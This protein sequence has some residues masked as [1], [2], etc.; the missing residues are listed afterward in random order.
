MTITYIISGTRPDLS[1]Q[2]T[3]PYSTVVTVSY[4]TN[5]SL[6]NAFN[7]IRQAFITSYE[8]TL[9]FTCMCSGTGN[10]RTCQCTDTNVP[11]NVVGMTNDITQPCINCRNDIIGAFVDLYGMSD[12]NAL[13]QLLIQY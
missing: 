7:L 10:Q 2:A 13:F 6:Q 1:I 11:P 3:D 4:N 5:D 8:S 9:T 12:D